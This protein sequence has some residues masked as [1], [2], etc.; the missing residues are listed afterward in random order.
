[1]QMFNILNNNFLTMDF[2]LRFRDRPNFG[3]SAKSCHMII[4]GI[5]SVLAETE[6]NNFQFIFKIKN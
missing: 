3:F 4:F 5:V 2:L 1:M 6:K